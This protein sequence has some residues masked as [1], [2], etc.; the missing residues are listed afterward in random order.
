M[1]LRERL[2]HILHLHES[3]QR[4]AAAFA[5]GVAIAFSPT[6]GLHT[7]SAFLCAWAFRLNAVAL[8]AGAFI[9][10]PW[11]L[12]PILGLTF[13]TGFAITGET[14]VTFEW[15]ELSFTSFYAQVSPYL[16]PFLAGGF[17]LSLLLG[18]LSYPLAYAVIT[19]YRAR[20]ALGSRR[21]EPLPP[22]G[23][24]G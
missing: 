9:N 6:Y 24:V 19:R 21:A 20:R 17:A 3:P 13:W 7:A 14:P 16:V 5:L 4:T 10:N 8:L 2:V 22:P 23:P 15:H 12:V 18:G 11:T 1:T